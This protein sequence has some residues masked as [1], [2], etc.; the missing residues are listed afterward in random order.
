MPEDTQIGFDNGPVMD[1]SLALASG[2]VL[3]TVGAKLVTVNDSGSAA[4]LILALG[5]PG[6]LIVAGELSS[7]GRNGSL[8]ML[9]FRYGSV[10][11]SSGVR[12]SMSPMQILL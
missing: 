9:P 2:V 1:R 4:G 8:S 6:E 3:R 5:D 10:C 11:C 7:H 12:A